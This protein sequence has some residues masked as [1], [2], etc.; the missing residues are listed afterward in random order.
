MYHGFDVEADR[1]LVSTLAAL[2]KANPDIKITL[3]LVDRFS[4]GAVAAVSHVAGVNQARPS[5]PQVVTRL[6][7]HVEFTCMPLGVIASIDGNGTSVENLRG[8]CASAPLR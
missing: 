5:S 8:A 7:R 1:G 3:L 4:G 6:H 2:L